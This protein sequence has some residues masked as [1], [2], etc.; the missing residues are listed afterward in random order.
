MKRREREKEREHTGERVT[1]SI[2]R[3]VLYFFPPPGPALCKLGKQGFLRTSLWSSDL[4]L[5]YFHG[6]FPSLSFSHHHFRM[7]FPI[8]PN[9][10]V[11][12]CGCPGETDQSSHLSPEFFKVA[13]TT[14]SPDPIFLG[15]LGS[16]PE[17]H[18]GLCSRQLHIFIVLL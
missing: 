17:T 12:K 11:P 5:F 15:L 18:C 10:N 14:F 7:L 2:W 4:P 16:I 6:L 3:L 9:K 1:Y 13:F 8:L